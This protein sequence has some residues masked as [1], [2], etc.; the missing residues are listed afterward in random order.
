V[1]WDA[2]VLLAMCAL[3][4][5][6]RLVPGFS[7]LGDGLVATVALCLFSVLPD[8]DQADEPGEVRASLR[9][10]ASRTVLIGGPLYAL[11]LGL[12][13]SRGW[14][15]AGTLLAR[16]GAT[17]AS[18]ALVAGAFALAAVLFSLLSRLLGLAHRKLL[19]SLVLPLA[20]AAAA[21][22]EGLPPVLALSLLAGFGSHALADALTPAGVYPLFPLS[23]RRLALGLARTGSWGEAALRLAFLLLFV[24]LCL[25]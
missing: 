2:H 4:L 12:R 17:L 22:A 10:A 7:P 24:A 23:S 13:W 14:R 20:G 11:H 5:L 6:E 16:S 3:P 25:Q 1:R 9:G 8:L 21:L 18:L 19:H 15:P